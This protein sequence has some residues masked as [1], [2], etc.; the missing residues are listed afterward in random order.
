MLNTF[1]FLNQHLESG[2][3]AGALSLIPVLSGCGVCSVTSEE[4]DPVTPQSH[5]PHQALLATAR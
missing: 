1:F 2:E 5:L 4:S 3:A